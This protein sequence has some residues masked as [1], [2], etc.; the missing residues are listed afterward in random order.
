MKTFVFTIAFAFMTVVAFGQDN[1]QS[2]KASK[3]R[4]ETRSQTQKGPNFVDKNN[5]GM[6]DNYEN[7]V[8]RGRGMGRNGK[9]A[10]FVDKDKDGICDNY[11]S[12]N[13]R[14]NGKRMG[15]K[16]KGRNF[17]DADKD[18]VCDNFQ[19]RRKTN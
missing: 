6:C 10:N 8:R 16:G 11:Q 3:T 1:Q 4:T 5:N 18:G 12:G 9:G 19:K 15:K 17:V 13:S 14:G 7:G 2:P